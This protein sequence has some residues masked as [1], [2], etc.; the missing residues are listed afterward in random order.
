[1]EVKRTSVFRATP[2]G[3]CNLVKPG[4]FALGDGTKQGHRPATMWNSGGNS[5]ATMWNSGGNSSYTSLSE[6]RHLR[7]ICSNCFLR[8]HPLTSPT[9]PAQWTLVFYRCPVPLFCFHAVFYW[10]S[11]IFIVHKV[12]VT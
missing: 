10:L 8:Q 11:L 9:S 2:L 12:N 3:P 6:K 5:P 4:V 1:M 7:L